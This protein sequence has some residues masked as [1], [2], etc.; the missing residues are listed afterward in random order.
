MALLVNGQATKTFYQLFQDHRNKSKFEI[1]VPD[2]QR[3]FVWD[4]VNILELW[5]DLFEIFEISIQNKSLPSKDS[6]LFLGNIIFLDTGKPNEKLEIIDGQQ[7]FTT[8]FILIIAFRAWLNE[9]ISYL[10]SIKSELGDRYSDEIKFVE[11]I[12]SNIEDLI[13]ESHSTHVE[14]LIFR[15]KGSDKVS[16][17]LK[18][19]YDPYWKGDFP[20]NISK[21]QRNIIKPIYDIFKDLLDE[22]LTKISKN[23][24]EV[25]ESNCRYFHQLINNLQFI[26]VTVSEMKEAYLFFERTNSRGKDL[27]VPDLVKAY[28]FGNRIE[29]SSDILIRE[30]NFISDNSNLSKTSTLLQ[31]FYI[32]LEKSTTKQNLFRKIKELYSP[33]EVENRKDTTKKLVENLKNYASFFHLLYNKIN[34]EKHKSEFIDYFKSLSK[35]DINENTFFNDNGKRVNKIYRAIEMLNF[36]GIKT[37]IPL[38]YSMLIKFFEFELERDNLCRDELANFFERTENLHFQFHVSGTEQKESQP[39]YWNFAS[40]F[41]KLGEESKKLE[42]AKAKSNNFKTYKFAGKSYPVKISSGD[43]NNIL[44]MEMEARAKLRNLNEYQF[45]DQNK[46]VKI[47]YIEAE[48]YIH[49]IDTSNKVLFLELLMSLY[50]ELD[51]IKPERDRFI[52]GFINDYKYSNNVKDKEHLRYVFDRFNNRPSFLKKDTAKIGESA[53]EP[54]FAPRRQFTTEYTIDHF[55][56]QNLAQNFEIEKERKNLESKIKE[57]DTDKKKKI[58]DDKIEELEKKIKKNGISWNDH[59]GNLVILPDQVNSACNDL[60]PSEKIPIIDK[61]GCGKKLKHTDEFIQK[62]ENEAT[63][64]T[65]NDLPYK[66]SSYSLIHQNAN[67]MAKVAFDS[68][69]KWEPMHKAIFKKV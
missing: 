9:Y 57:K 4:K 63:H 50:N 41:Y 56:P 39:T 32:S 10:K 49:K 3:N 58:I 46:E 55:Y 45:L 22:N 54:I 60:P 51:K 42:E 66:D 19:M 29:M 18:Y 15:F 68:I 53:R 67:D 17:I 64:A 65:W 40:K 5:D 59:I 30:W 31:Y 62:I 52:M 38:F 37:H 27:Q 34:Y 35:I 12:S 47:K 23:S 14:K 24:E 61:S 44:A 36:F 69:W 11:R 26:E 48:K 13:Y 43:A 28:I 16:E 25:E 20:D 8:L 6:G 2:F 21:T 33:N 7:R 1:I